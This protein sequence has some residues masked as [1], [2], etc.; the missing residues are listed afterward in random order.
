MDSYSSARRAKSCTPVHVD[1]CAAAR[2]SASYSPEW[3][4]PP[5]EFRPV[6][7][8]PLQFSRLCCSKIAMTASTSPNAEASYLVIVERA[9]TP[10]RKELTPPS[11][12]LPLAPPPTRSLRPAGS[13]DPPPPP[14][15][16]PPPPPRRPP[17]RRRPLHRRRRRRPLGGAPRPL[18]REARALPAPEAA[19]A[20]RPPPP[21]PGDER[22]PALLRPRGSPKAPSSPRSAR[23][24]PRRS[25][26]SATTRRA[27]KRA[28]RRCRDLP[29]FAP[30]MRATPPRPTALLRPAALR[31][32][33]HAGSPR[34]RRAR[35]A[36][37]RTS[38]LSR[39][40]PPTLLIWNSSLPSLTL[41]SLRAA[42]E[43]NEARG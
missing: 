14:P 34:R 3:T 43:R 21:A 6:R 37:P 29:P 19:C 36:A 18:G 32:G 31:E 42:A 23:P 38:A 40:F 27:A 22:R 12:P 20:P 26:R 30:A 24:R 16:S 8:E 39:E 9:A 4:P 15:P 11:M 7:R 5:N 10:E 33:A 41:I 1:R 28:P 13:L 17:R 25:A 2:P 35:R